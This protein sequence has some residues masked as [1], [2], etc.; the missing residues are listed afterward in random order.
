MV[1][2]ACTR[3]I[4]PPQGLLKWQNIKSKK[5]K[6]GKQE[7]LPELLDIGLMEWKVLL[8]S[9]ETKADPPKGESE[10][11]QC[12]IQ[13]HKR[14]GLGQGVSTKVNALKNCLQETWGHRRAFLM[15]PCET[16]SRC[17]VE[18]GVL[19]FS[20]QSTKTMPPGNRKTASSTVELKP[21]TCALKKTCCLLGELLGWGCQAQDS[22][23][24]GHTRLLLKTWHKWEK[25]STLGFSF[26]SREMKHTFNVPSYPRTSLGTGYCLTRLRALERI[27]HALHA[28]QGRRQWEQERLLKIPEKLQY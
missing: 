8:K 28:W 18:R 1:D 23:D 7:N 3:L 6:T 19:I 13:P 24:Q 15:P 20:C 26:R 9:P 25:I 11:N 16:G 5:N 2:Q 21:K 27:L 10:E 22:W 14:K 4:L 17:R 12:G